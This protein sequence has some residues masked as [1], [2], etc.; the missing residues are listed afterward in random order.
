LYLLA[1][2]L[3]VSPAALLADDNRLTFNGYMNVESD[4]QP[5]K[6]GLGDKNFSID[7]DVLELLLNYKADDNFRVSGALDFE[8]GTDA[9]FNQGHLTTGW[10]FLEYA[11]SDRL[12]LR[13]GK[14]LVPFGFFNE[15]HGAKNLFLARDEARATLKPQKIAKNAFR[16]APKWETGL[17]AFGR[18]AINKKQS[19]DYLVM[20]GNGYQTETNPYE[21]DNNDKKSVTARVLYQPTDELSIGVSGYSDFLSQDSGGGTRWGRQKS[22]G[23]FVHYNAE[24]WKILYEIN[25]GRMRVPGGTTTARELGQAAEVGYALAHHITPYVQVQNVTTHLNSTTEQ[26]RAYIAGFDYAVGH[27]VFKLQDAE[28]SGSSP[29]KKFNFPGRRY[30]ELNIALFYAF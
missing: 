30:N 12:K 19:I 24:R 29:N 20:V 3:L 27:F 1:L 5:T 8:H 15:I 18:L 2:A 9:E 16:Y 28:W 6:Y 26:A 25:Q 11:F 13:A 4:Y 21:Q 14:M 7:A 17:E 10:L 23:T 22:L